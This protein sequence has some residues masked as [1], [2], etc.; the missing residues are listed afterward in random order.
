MAFCTE[1]CRPRGWAAFLL[2]CRE[3]RKKKEGFVWSLPPEVGSTLS[4]DYEGAPAPAFPSAGTMEN[5]KDPKE[6]MAWNELLTGGCWFFTGLKGFELEG[7]SKPITSNP[8][9]WPGT[10]PTSS[11][12]SNLSLDNSRGGADHSLHIPE[13]ECEWR[14]CGWH[15]EQRLAPAARPHGSSVMLVLGHGWGHRTLWS[16]GYHVNARV[17]SSII[18]PMKLLMKIITLI[19]KLPSL[20]RLT[21]IKQL[22]YASCTAK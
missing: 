4:D 10:P 11:G 6:Q 12:C 15:G 16:C 17:N 9:Q 22:C 1:C 8:Q 20:S 21:F 2:L 19:W 13:D 14:P 18:F 3:K 5:K 7:T